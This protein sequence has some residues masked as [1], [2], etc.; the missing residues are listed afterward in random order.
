MRLGPIE[1]PALLL[2]LIF[3]PVAIALELLHVS[4][5]W[6]FICSGLA[7]I[8]LAGL[9]GESTEHLSCHVG[10]GLG[11]L[12][13]ATFGNAAEMILALLALKAGL[14]EVVKASITGSILGNVLLVFGLAILTGGMRHRKQSFNSTAASLGAALLGLSAV[15]LM[16]PAA[17]HAIVPDPKPSSEHALSLAI[18]IVLFLVYGLA[19]LFQL[20]TH[21]HLFA[22]EAPSHGHGSAIHWS[23]KRAVITLVAATVG[24]AF[25][26]HMLIGAVEHTAHVWGMNEVFVGVILLAIIGNAAEHSTA[27]LV[28]MKNQMDLSYTIAIGS[29]IQIALFVAPVLLFCSYAFGQPMDLIFTPFEVAAVAMTVGVLALVAL[30]GSSHW[31]EGVLLLAVYV[32]LGIAFFFMP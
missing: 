31:M 32:I 14:I 27:V 23:M 26:A 1:I 28:A 20:V 3:V 11:G 7:V 5:V 4:P 16:V 9:M 2:L 21:K 13:N 6:V 22:G 10:P 8:P 17:F 18:A 15:G 30:D 19:L 25:M 12:L 24:V 29:S